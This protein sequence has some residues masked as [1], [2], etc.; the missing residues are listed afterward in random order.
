MVI[1]IVS[2]IVVVL[3]ASATVALGFMGIRIVA[4]AHQVLPGRLGVLC[5]IDSALSFLVCLA[6][7]LVGLF[8]IYIVLTNPYYVANKIGQLLGLP[9]F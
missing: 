7:M 9:P 3:F 5:A 4:R 1:Q 8:L 6:T 2:N